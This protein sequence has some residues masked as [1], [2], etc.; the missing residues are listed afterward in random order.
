MRLIT[1]VM[2][3]ENQDNETLGHRAPCRAARSHLTD[4]KDLPKKQDLKT[5]SEGTY[6]IFCNNRLRFIMKYYPQMSTLLGGKKERQ[7]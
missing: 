7:A 1:H 2:G 4:T 5:I 6:D 3:S